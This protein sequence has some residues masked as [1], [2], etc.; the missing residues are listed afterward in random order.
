LGDPA[1]GILDIER[2]RRLDPAGTVRAL[3][4]LGLGHLLLGKY[5]TAAAYF[6]ERIAQHPKTD[7]SRAMLAATLGHLGHID[8]AKTIWA[9]LME[10]NP[11]Y[12]FK[13]HMSRLPFANPSDAERIGQGLAKAGLAD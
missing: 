3:H 2:A 12:S 10:I 7:L 4:L 13:I 5:E 8:E 11:S 9:E 1:A 6:R